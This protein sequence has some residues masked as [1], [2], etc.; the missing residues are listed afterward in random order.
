MTIESIQPA[1]FAAP[2][3]RMQQA[4][5]PALAIATF[6]HYYSE[7]IQGQTGLL[8]EAEIRPVSDVPRLA[9]LPEAGADGQAALA[10]T[11]MIK[12]N[13]GLGTSMGLNQAKSL[14]P[15]RAGASFLELIARQC[16]S[17]R[18]RTGQALPLILMNSFSTEA[19][20]LDLLNAIPGLADGQGDIP[21]SFLQ[22][23]VPRLLE[24]DL[25][26]VAWPDEPHRE[27]CPP[28]HGDLYTA[29]ETTGL[30]DQL[31]ARD[32]RFAF[33][34]NADNLGASLDLDILALMER[35]SVPFLMEVTR[36]TAADRKGGHVALDPTGQLILRESAQCPVEDQASFQDIE[37]HRYFNTNNLWLDLQTLKETMAERDGI[38]GL[39]LIKNRKHVVPDDPSTPAVIQVETAMG[40]A[41]SVFPGARILEVPRTRFAPVKTTNDLL[42]L[43]SDRYRVDASGQVLPTTDTPLTVDLDPT[44]YGSIEQFRARFPAGAPSLLEAREFSLRGD[45]RFENDVVLSGQVHLRHAGKA[46]RVIRAGS[47]LVEVDER[48]EPER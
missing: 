19:D 32:I 3:K 6:R 14:L 27:W 21:L 41:I 13:G 47:E 25:S 48:P 15:A 35:E 10:R 8:G 20:S 4:G 29:L 16:L 17:L 2:E 37:R 11:V 43:W 23:R 9:E 34:S 12:L 36:R 31:L 45:I 46:Q 5:L 40:A 42:V 18:Q 22:H 33:V 7:L 39:P 28:G 30:L 24:E 38:L 44:W 26:P 1:G